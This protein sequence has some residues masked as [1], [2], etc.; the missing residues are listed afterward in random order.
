MTIGQKT[1]Y[2]FIYSFSHEVF[3]IRYEKKSS[4]AISCLGIKLRADVRRLSLL[5]SSGLMSDTDCPPSAALDIIS[6]LM[7]ETEVV[8]E[9]L[10][11]N[12]KTKQ[13]SSRDFTACSC[14][15]YS[16]FILQFV[17]IRQV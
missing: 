4:R 17:L 7:M 6:T 12:T 3:G 10:D 1:I 15:Q 13:P 9:T 2:L 8:S 16:H 11:C 5:P 14:Q